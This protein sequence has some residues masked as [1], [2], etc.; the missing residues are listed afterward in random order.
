MRALEGTHRDIL[1]QYKKAGIALHEESLAHVERVQQVQ[2]QYG[3]QDTP[4]SNA[5]GPD[6]VHMRDVSAPQQHS[7]G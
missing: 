6:D 4:N 1:E 2:E 3:N 7:Q 5:S